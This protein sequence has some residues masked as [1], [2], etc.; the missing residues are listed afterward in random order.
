M[1][2]ELLVYERDLFLWLNSFHT[3]F[4]NQFFWT[5][6]GKITWLP[7]AVVILFLLVYRKQWKKSLFLVLAIA[8]TIVLCDQF[9]SH[10]CKPIF[11]RFRPTHHPDFMNEVRTVFGYR[12]GRYGFISSHAAN[13]FGFATF[14]SLV[15]RN[16]W[17]TFSLFFW[18][19]VNSYSRIYLGV[20]FISDII[21]GALSGSFFGWG[22]YKAYVY[23][24]QRYL[25][26][27]GDENMTTSGGYEMWRIRAMVIAMLA[28]HLAILL[29]AA[30]AS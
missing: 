23:A 15:I 5:Y 3:P 1:L 11:T 12:G 18:A 8:L 10:V 4:W 27:T 25:P 6:S 16:K 22:V 7:L 17:L 28:T 29:W 21:P 19:I 2:E 14:L 24:E 13:A 30:I 20:H 26:N 9:A